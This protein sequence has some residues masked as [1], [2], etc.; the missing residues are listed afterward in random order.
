MFN[1][2]EA[3]ERLRSKKNEKR[4]ERSVEENVEPLFPANNNT[5]SGDNLEDRVS[6]L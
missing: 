2:K 6:K 5:Q 3:L 1:P 4:E